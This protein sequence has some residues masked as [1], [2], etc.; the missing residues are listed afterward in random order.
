LP[1]FADDKAEPNIRCADFT[2]QP[3]R[4]PLVATAAAIHLALS[5]KL[6]EPATFDLREVAEIALPRRA[7][8]LSAENSVVIASLHVGETLRRRIQSAVVRRSSCVAFGLVHGSST[9]IPRASAV[10]VLYAASISS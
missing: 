7:V 8:A 9:L 1:D 6:L 10:I 3:P 2:C 4:E 5:P